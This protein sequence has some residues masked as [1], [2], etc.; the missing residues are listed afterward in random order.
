MA[1]I[2]V[3]TPGSFGNIFGFIAGVVGSVDINTVKG[4]V[5]TQ[6]F[7]TSSIDFRLVFDS[8][9]N[10]D[11]PGQQ[12]LVGGTDYFNKDSSLTVGGVDTRWTWTPPNISSDLE[13]A[14]NSSTT[15]T[16]IFDFR[17]EQYTTPELVAPYGNQ[18]TLVG[19]T[20]DIDLNTNFVI[21][22]DIS[23]TNLPPGLSETDGVVTGTLTGNTGPFEVVVTATNSIG[24]TEVTFIWNTYVI[25]AA[26]S[27][28]IPVN[29]LVNTGVNLL[30]SQPFHPSAS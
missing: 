25:G 29:T 1:T 15:V 16:V 14:F 10:N 2:R 19:D 28:N 8:V 7:E 13:E 11:F 12:L 9:Q 21:A 3:V 17:A 24:T 23:A 5:L 4:V 22:N 30:V 6:L 27:I 20:V 18:G 26:N